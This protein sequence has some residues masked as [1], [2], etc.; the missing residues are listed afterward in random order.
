MSLT[1]DATENGH[2][3][4]PASIGGCQDTRSVQQLNGERYPSR[5]VRTQRKAKQATTCETMIVT[6]M[7]LRSFVIVLPAALLALAIGCA[8]PDT[9]GTPD[10]GDTGGTAGITDLG[11]NPDQGAGDGGQDDPASGEPGGGPNDTGANGSGDIT[12]SGSNPDQDPGDG[13][14]DEPGSG[15][16]ND[17]PG[18]DPID[19]EPGGSGGDPD[20]APPDVIVPSGDPITASLVF[21]GPQG[22]RVEMSPLLYNPVLFTTEATFVSI[23]PSAI[24]TVV[25]LCDDQI[26]LGEVLFFDVAGNATSAGEVVYDRG[27]G[28]EC[29][30]E[31]TIQFA[32]PSDVTLTVP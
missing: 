9:N 7:K 23:M 21:E 17:E 6:L 25:F 15:D 12:D 18:G 28:Y 24:A 10:S 27:A 29:G 1:N 26:T 3:P 11:S 13:V 22:T 4:T 14:P 20:Q 2:T 30:Q 16:P 8:I 31:V 32:L 5:R 19:A